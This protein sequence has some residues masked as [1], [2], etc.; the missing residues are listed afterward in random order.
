MSNRKYVPESIQAYI[1][2]SG[3]AHQ[4][5]RQSDMIDVFFN[6]KLTLFLQYIVNMVKLRYS[7]AQGT[8]QWIYFAIAVIRDSCISNLL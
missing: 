1:V 5:R 6:E 8:M 3:D 2:P 4:V 7:E